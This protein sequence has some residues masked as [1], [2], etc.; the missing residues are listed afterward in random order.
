MKNHILFVCFLVSSIFGFSQEAS[1]PEVLTADSS[2]TKEV[3]KFPL[4]FAPDIDFEGYEDIRFSKGWRKQDQEDFW[5]YAFTWKVNLTKEL[6]I[7]SLEQSFQLYYDGIMKA[8]NKDKDFTVPESTILFIKDESAKAPTYIGKLN[9]YDSFA[10]K[11]M[12]KLNVHLEYR[13]CPTT[14]ELIPLFRISPQPF[15]HAIWKELHN[16]TLVDNACDH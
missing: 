2:W 8:V 4:G 12:I 7:A 1:L 14:Q 13:L 3:I 5:T 11:K 15:D 16:V 9:V 10:S 6:T